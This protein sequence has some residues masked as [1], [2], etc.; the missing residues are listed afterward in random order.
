MSTL[1]Q[2]AEPH[3]P[4][5][6]RTYRIHGRD[7]ELETIGEQIAVLASGRGSVTLLAG[8]AGVGKS[9][10]LE[11]AVRVARRASVRVGTGVAERGDRV[12]PMNALMGAFFG[13]NAPLLDA[14]VLPDLH[15]KPEQRYWLIQEFESLLEKAV[16]GGPLMICLDDLQW[17]DSGTEAALDALTVRLAGL[18]IAWFAC[19]RTGYETAE[20]SATTARLQRAGAALLELGALD[21]VAVSQIIA[22]HVGGQADTALLQLADS[23][24]G[25]PFWLAELLLGLQ[26]EDLL[27]IEDGVASLREARLPARIRDTMRERLGRMSPLARSAATAGSVLGRLFSFEALSRMLDATAVALLEAVHELLHADLLVEQGSA[28]GFRHDILRDAVLESVPVA[29]RAALQRQGVDALLVGGAPPL[30]VAAQLAA[31]AQPGD[32]AAVDVLVRA[33]RML[34]TS[35][36]SAAARL[37]EQTLKL[38]KGEDPRRGPLVAETALLLHAAGQLD[39]GRVFAETALRGLLPV[40]QESEVLF[41]IAGMFALSADM[42]TEAGRRALALPGLRTIDRAR[43]QA[44]LIHNLMGAGRSSQ[45]RQLIDELGDELRA[46]GDPAVAFTLDLTEGVL[47]YE[48]GNFQPSL[49]RIEV[50]TQIAA[51]AGESV[52]RQIAQEWQA[53]PYEWH[54]EVLAVLDRYDEADATLSSGLQSAQMES[55]AGAIRLL[56]KWRGRQM[57]QRGDL[58]D[59]I[60]VLEGVLGLDQ[61]P[62]LGCSDA[63]ALWALARA[64][65]HVGD[66]RL[67]HACAAWATEALGAGTPEVRRYAAWILAQQAMAAGDAQRARAILLAPGFDPADPPLPSFS[68]DVTNQPLLVRLALAAGDRALARSAVTRAED[69]L[70]RNPEVSS[71][72]GA[73]AHAAGLFWA[74]AKSMAVAIDELTSGPRRPALASAL[75]DAGVMARDDGRTEDAI[76][77]LGRALEAYAEIGAVWDSTRV[78]ARL[79]RL[80]VRRRLVASERPAEGWEALTDSERKVVLAVTRGMTNREVGQQL[81]ISPH[82]VNSHLRRAFAKLK[83][84]SRVELA[85]IAA[86][87]EVDSTLS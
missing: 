49:A 86:Q 43:H 44:R 37:G 16:R 51:S 52:R 53:I 67:T 23:A 15:S 54:A 57:L 59:A 11:E 36:P 10:V 26:E 1:H 78:R 48:A 50:A 61:T 13:G 18:P 77:L 47:E 34:G 3:M 83:L 19:F 21:G 38:I 29:G 63:P 45:A 56:E 80:G 82:T 66:Q 84:N 79:R 7:R 55:Q 42:R 30:E 40:D 72:R 22:D 32:S 33:V 31:S 62:G 28:L 20:L 58:T 25:T 2:L 71:V 39:E 75:E 81:F 70:S 60:A 73:A 87:Y 24:H 64:A 5:A 8:P 6:T 17:A 46:A 4:L 76:A 35:D 69:R 74:D 65:L 9:R 68:F 12:V 41:S 14:T 85:R 27:T